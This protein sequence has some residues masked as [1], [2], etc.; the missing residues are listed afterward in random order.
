MRLLLGT[1]VPRENHA[2]CGNVAYP[3]G[4]ANLEWRYGWAP[5]SPAVATQL[6]RLG[7]LESKTHSDLINRLNEPNL[8]DQLALRVSSFSHLENQI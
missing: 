3:C 5:I 8:C 1:L 7:L 2:N 4:C 6:L